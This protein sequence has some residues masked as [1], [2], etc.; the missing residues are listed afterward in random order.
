MQRAPATPW[1]Q[2]EL[3]TAQEEDAEL[4]QKGPAECSHAPL[5]LVRSGAPMERVG[6]DV[7]GPFP[8]TERGNKYVLVAMDY[9]TKWPEACAVPDQR[10]HYNGELPS[11]TIFQSVWSSSGEEDRL[12]R[13]GAEL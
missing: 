2:D 13:S 5:Q 4:N 10:H 3:R 8:E 11:G 1:G 7:L 9:F 12:Q 6:V